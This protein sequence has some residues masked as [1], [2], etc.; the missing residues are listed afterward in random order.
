MFSHPSFSTPGNCMSASSFQIVKFFVPIYSICS[1]STNYTSANRILLWLWEISPSA[2]GY[3]PGSAALRARH[4]V[5]LFSSNPTDTLWISCRCSKT[6][7]RLC[8][9]PKWVH[10]IHVCGYFFINS[11]VTS[12]ESQGPHYIPDQCPKLMSIWNSL[13]DIFVVLYDVCWSY[14]ILFMWTT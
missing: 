10:N 9:D 12:A 6:E 14:L 3:W 4:A 1:S 8:L 13:P 2:V 5:L 7:T 11:G